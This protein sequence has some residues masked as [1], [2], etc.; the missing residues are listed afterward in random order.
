MSKR[1]I[2]YCTDLIVRSGPLP[3][4]ELAERVSAA[5][6]TTARKPETTV[7]SALSRSSGIIRLPDGRYDAVRRM[8]DGSVLTHRVRAATTGRNVLFAGHELEP[9]DELFAAGPLPLVSGGEVRRSASDMMGLY[10]PPG[11]VPDVP[12]DTLLALRFGAGVLAVTA[13][14]DSAET[15]D[16]RAGR[17][18]GVVSRH[19]G[20]KDERPAA[21]WRYGYDEWPDYT[22]TL[23]GWRRILS[24][25]LLRALAECPDLL[26]EPMPPLDEVLRLP[27][28]SWGEVWADQDR[29][30]HGVSSPQRG[31]TLTLHGVPEGLRTALQQQATSSRTPLGEFVVL[32]LAAATYRWETPC[33][34]DA[35]Q[36][37]LERFRADE[38]DIDPPYYPDLNAPPDEPGAEI[39]PFMA[40]L[41]PAGPAASSAPHSGRRPR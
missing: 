3:L 33:R 19:L 20:T 31:V 39:V 11:W 5:G 1:I 4:D 41:R 40:S 23:T 9:F 15:M 24:H 30:R 17:L 25:G 2:T 36:A 8:L 14:E 26:A 29:L 18:L 27:E 37:W 28:M 16:R 35:E 38:Y 6:L 12:A 13:V 10:G 21:S 34:H 32:Q 7:K 22:R